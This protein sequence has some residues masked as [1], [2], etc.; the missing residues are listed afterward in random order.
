MELKSWCKYLLLTV[1]RH[2]SLFLTRVLIENHIILHCIISAGP[3]AVYL[4]AIRRTFSCGSM[5]VLVLNYWSKLL[6]SSKRCCLE[7]S[8]LL[9]GGVIAYSWQYEFK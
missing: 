7:L 5:F 4:Y 3:L 1:Y 8:W 9:S 2:Y 6:L